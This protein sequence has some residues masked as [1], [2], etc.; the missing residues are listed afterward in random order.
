MPFNVPVSVGQTVTITWDNEES[1][2]VV[3]VAGKAAA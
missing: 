2:Y 3:T 1:R